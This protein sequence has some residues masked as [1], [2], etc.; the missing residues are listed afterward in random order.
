M[1]DPDHP[2]HFGQLLP[3]LRAWWSGPRPLQRLGA[4]AIVAL[5][6]LLSPLCWWND[7]LFNLP[8][9]AGFAKVVSYW[10]PEWFLP[11]LAAGYW[12]SNVV[13]IVLMQSGALGLLSTERPPDRLRELLLG[14]GTSTLYTLAVLLCVRLGWLHAP[15]ALLDAVAG[16]HGSVA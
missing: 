1:S 12:L 10:R 11:A 13:G 6:W 14:L 15:Q 9:A 8:L 5:G 2:F 16:A 7:L 4:L 3:R